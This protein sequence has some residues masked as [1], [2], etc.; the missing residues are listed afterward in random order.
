MDNGGMLSAGTC[1]QTATGPDQWWAVD[2]DRDYL[3]YRVDIHNRDDC[4]GN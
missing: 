1:S 3:I 2:L 4:C